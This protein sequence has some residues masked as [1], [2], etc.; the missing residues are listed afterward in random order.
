M[1]QLVFVEDD[2]L[3]TT[4]HSGRRPSGETSSSSQGGS[5]R[6]RSPHSIISPLSFQSSTSSRPSLV[7]GVHLPRMPSQTTFG[8][9]VS[10][11]VE[12]GHEFGQGHGYGRTWSRL[13]REG[14]SSDSFGFSFSQQQQQLSVNPTVR[15]VDP[16][17]SWGSFSLP[18]WLGG[19]QAQTDRNDDQ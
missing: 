9:R 2:P 7:P 18:Q 8:R 16:R 1:L 10:V 13:G 5:S 3:Q 4:S 15:L 11:D 19:R 6:L 17:S 14:R 12:S